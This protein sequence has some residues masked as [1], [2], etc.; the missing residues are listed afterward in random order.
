MSY[1]VIEK[2]FN[3]VLKNRRIAQLGL[4]QGIKLVINKKK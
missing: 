1:C 4:Q 2:Y 3:C